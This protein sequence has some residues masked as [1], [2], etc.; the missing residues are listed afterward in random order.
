MTGSA[1]R[2]SHDRRG[3]PALEGICSEEQLEWYRMTVEERWIEN[4]RMWSTFL[5]LGGR[6]EPE[7]DRQSPFF[8]PG[9]RH[10]EPP[11][12]GAG[13]HPLRRR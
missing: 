1:R 4:E 11:H 10:P 12:G 9:E 5:D 2:R 7:P 6:L 3:S 8:A 13:V